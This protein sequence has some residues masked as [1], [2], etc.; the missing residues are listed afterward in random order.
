[1]SLKS[2]RIEQLLS[3]LKTSGGSTVSELAESLNVTEITV[4][5]YLNQL[6]KTNRVRLLNRGVML[7]DTQR[8]YAYSQAA[9]VHT[10]EKKRI[11]EKA[12]SL[13]EPH[14]TI[15]IDSGS[16]TEFL[17]EYINNETPVTV[18]SYALNI[19]NIIC[20]KQNCSP[21][22]AGGTYYRN[23]LSFIGPSCIE[24]MKQ[25]R[26]SKVFISASGV[27]DKLGV[28]VLN[29]YEIEPKKSAIESSETRILLADSSKFDQVKIAHVA[30]LDDFD[31]I[32]TD[33]NVPKR[34]IDYAREHD[35]TLFMV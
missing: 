5:R 22:I 17:A 20:N 15:I 25:I 27:S 3:N 31:I 30:N 34:Y 28:T 29:L 13:I 11:G 26:A 33:A 35:I 21:I 2:D 18:L 23:T 6:E 12:A 8:T 10:Q 24:L 19:I 9:Q 16:T 14:D 1:M 32:I 4:R 7:L